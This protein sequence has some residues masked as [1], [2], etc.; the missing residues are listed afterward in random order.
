MISKLLSFCIKYIIRQRK[1]FIMLGR[2]ELTFQELDAL[3]SDSLLNECRNDNDIEVDEIDMLGQDKALEALDFGLK[4]DD[5]SYNIYLAGST[6][7]NKATFIEGY[8]KEQAKSLDTPDDWCYVYNFKDPSMP[9]PIRLKAGKGK[10]LKDQMESFIQDFGKEL[11]KQFDSLE[12]QLQKTK[13]TNHYKEKS[14]NLMKQ[15]KLDAQACNFETQVTDK[16]IYFIPVLDGEKLSE[17]MFD[18]LSKEEQDDIIEQSEVLQQHATKVLK[19]VRE[20]QRRADEKVKKLQTDIALILLRD[21]VLDLIEEYNDN[22]DVTTY[23]KLV[24]KDIVDNINQWIDEEDEEEGLLSLL[25]SLYKSSDG[26]HKKRYEVNLM[27]DN[28]ET[29]G[30]PV[31]YGINPSFYNLIGKIEQ[32]SE[33]GSTKSDFTKIR[34][35]ILHKANGGILILE[36]EELLVHAYS[37]YII[38]LCL[39]SGKIHYKEIK[40]STTLST[41]CLRP[42]PM[43]L[44]VKIVLIGKRRHYYLL[45]DLEPIFGELFKMMVFFPY[46][47]KKTDKNKLKLVHFVRDFLK[48]KEVSDIDDE[49]MTSLFK[50][51][52][53]QVMES[54]KFLSNLMPIKELLV[55]CCHWAKAQ[56]SKTIT[57]EVMERTLKEKEQRVNYIEE[58]YD[59]LFDREHILIDVDGK[60]IGQINA[61][62]VLD[63]GDH[64][65]AKPTRITATA[66]KGKAGIINIEKESNMSG[67]I[68]DKG[69]HVLTGYLGNKYA[70]EYPLSLTCQICFEQSYSGVDGDSASSAELYAIISSLS[71]IPIA[72]NM[73]VTGSINQFGDIQSIGGVTL[74]VEGFYH[75]CKERG[76]TG[77]QGVIIPYQN[78]KDLVLK[79]E[80]LEAVRDGK[81]HIYPVTH[82]DEALELLLGQEANLIHKTIEERLEVERQRNKKDD[83]KDKKES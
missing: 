45:K 67:S 23:L 10:I 73:A 68:H 70:R 51:S 62:A 53:R 57:K 55:E 22:E 5:K 42:V 34:P 38:K 35:G 74:K 21:H 6:I 65:F 82:V 15:M 12:F 9:I 54:D 24:E 83:K 25:P 72:Q 39:K 7:Q 3:C 56:G 14:E 33:L 49:A 41:E 2:R 43:P 77:D 69:V 79:D 36:L 28:S 59:E 31:V 8:I 32:E 27:I 17:E 18:E 44:D 64:A 58:R 30:K 13:I 61:L 40:D 60:K 75:L 19:A 78:V 26:D 47:A 63:Y 37:W 80:V 76:L 50:F 20:T 11:T 4:I 52:T 1:E 71:E 81:F 46:D 16:D 29:E 48:E 66:F